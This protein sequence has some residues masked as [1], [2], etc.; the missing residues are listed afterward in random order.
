MSDEEGGA[1]G[2]VVYK[3]T[4]VTTAGGYAFVILRPTQPLRKGHGGKGREEWRLKTK[5]NRKGLNAAIYILLRTPPRCSVEINVFGELGRYFT[6]S[7]RVVGEV[8]KIL[9]HRY[10]EISLVSYVVLH[11]NLTRANTLE[12]MIFLG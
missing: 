7:H 2:T 5:S 3:Q 12:L 10:G 4:C 6:I 1:T 9:L 11:S 8:I